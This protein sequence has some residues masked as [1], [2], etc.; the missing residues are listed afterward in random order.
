MRTKR[1]RVVAGAGRRGKNALVEAI[2]TEIL[3]A[4]EAGAVEE[5]NEALAE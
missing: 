2:T 1:G 3:D 5:L 4:P